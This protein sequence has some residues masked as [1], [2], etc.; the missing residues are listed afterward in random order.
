MAQ[1]DGGNATEPHEIMCCMCGVLIPPN[2]ASMCVNCVRT[3]VDI[4]DG[5]P[6][7]IPIQWC[8]GCNRFQHG[9]VWVHCE[10][11]SRELLSMLVKKVRGLNKV[12]LVDAGFVW[13][14]P[15]SR[16]IK[17]KLT[18]QKEVFVSTILQQVFIVEFSQQNQ[19]CELCHKAMTAHTWTSSV[20]LRQHV[21]HKRTIYFLEQVI[22]KNSAHQN[23]IGLK[24]L[25][26]GLDFFFSTQSHAKKFNEY[27]QAVSPTRFQQAKQLISKDEHSNTYNYHYTWSV[28]V[29]PICREDLVC[30]PLRVY[31]ALGGS[32]GPL[33][34]CHKVT[35]TIHV[36]DP[37]TLKHAE[38]SAAGYWSAPFRALGNAKQLVEF[39]VMDINPIRCQNYGKYSL[40]EA[41]VIKTSELGHG[42]PIFCRTH[43]GS[44][45]KSGDTVLGYYI[46]NINWNDDDAA[47]LKGRQVADVVL[48]KKSFQRRAGRKNKQRIWELQRLAR[49]DQEEDHQPSR[50]EQEEARRA[51]EDYEGLLRDLEE[52]PELRA[53]VNMYKVAGAEE[54]IRKVAARA[55]RGAPKPTGAGDDDMEGEE[56]EAE[57]EGG[58]GEG[59][60][61]DEDAEGAE[62]D[63]DEEGEA[64]EDAELGSSED[65]GDYDVALPEIQ[66][67][68][69]LEPLQKLNLTASNTTTPTTSTATPNNGGL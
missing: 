63:G 45:L 64:G 27:I 2:P 7:Q 16:R 57:E 12:T 39:T 52:D 31:T 26:D 38:I 67:S 25:P 30:L 34:L 69:L 3:Q 22:L 65:E 5:I 23:I 55:G 29:V 13:T 18:I 19:F 20:Q 4:T 6:K 42:A 46:P 24:E 62:G 11:E 54:M 49:E 43:L 1:M 68:E 47:A 44:I 37:T 41:E 56:A 17:I 59:E 10:P 21:G 48:V 35:S 40:A 58:E 66:L 28:E 33:C 50:K 60:E 36:L 9:N 32:V 53:S 51:E 8:K 61:V 14:E 15:H